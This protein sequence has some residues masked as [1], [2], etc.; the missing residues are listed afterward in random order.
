MAEVEARP[1]SYWEEL[2]RSVTEPGRHVMFVACE[3]DAVR[4]SIYGLRDAEGSAAGRVGGSWVEPPY[5][6]RGIGNALLRAVISWARVE[7]LELLR[8]WAPAASA[9]ALAFYRQAGFSETGQRRPLPTN[10]A[11]EVVELQ[12]RLPT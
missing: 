10:A 7:R 6:R 9:G 1:A 12:C 4:G 5:R 3:G 2:T 8:L 11:L